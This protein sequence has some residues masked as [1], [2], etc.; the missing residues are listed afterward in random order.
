MQMLHTTSTNNDGF[1]SS[2]PSVVKKV[3]QA[4]SFLSDPKKRLEYG[5]HTFLLP[6]HLPQP[7]SCCIFR[8]TYTLRSSLFALRSSL[9][10]LRSSLFAL[11]SSLFAL[12]SSLFAL[13][14]SRFALRASLFALRSSRFALRAS[15]FALTYH[16]NVVAWATDLRTNNNKSRIM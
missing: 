10:A 7:I 13:R 6:H 8:S 14:S 12:R 4:Y 9:F 1:P 5:I 3:A 11:R 16:N 15:L 2:L